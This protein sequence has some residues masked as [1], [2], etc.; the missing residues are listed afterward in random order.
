MPSYSFFFFIIYNSVII[1]SPKGTIITNRFISGFT[2]IIGY[3][4]VTY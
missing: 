4:L 3:N 2:I 1:I